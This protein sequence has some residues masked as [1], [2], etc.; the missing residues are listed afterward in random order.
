MK[1][2][3]QPTLWF[4][5]IAVELL[6]HGR[7]R[8]GHYMVA[9][10]YLGVS[11]DENTLTI[12]HQTAKRDALWQDK[13]HHWLLS[14]ESAFDNIELSHIGIRDGQALHTRHVSL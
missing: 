13:L 2:T 9:R 4:G 6:E 5:K 14:D 1:N 12:A 8:E 10:S 11:V 7:A 3:E